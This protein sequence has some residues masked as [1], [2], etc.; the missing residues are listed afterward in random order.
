L[1]KNIPS[2]IRNTAPGK[3][4]QKFICVPL[5][6]FWSLEYHHI[7]NVLNDWEMTKKQKGLQNHDS[8]KIA[9][10]D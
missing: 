2:L 1:K 8:T 9:E 10:K 6:L 7:K 3:K 4:V 5:C